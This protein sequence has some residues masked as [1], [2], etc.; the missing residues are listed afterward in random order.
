VF[1]FPQDGAGLTFVATVLLASSTTREPFMAP[2]LDTES[3]EASYHGQQRQ[4]L[5]RGLR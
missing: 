5:R 2:L 3:I 1:A 4:Q